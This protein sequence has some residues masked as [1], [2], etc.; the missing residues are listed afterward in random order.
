MEK[1]DQKYGG[2]KR[3]LQHYLEAI[4]RASPVEET[5]L[6]KL[7]I[8]TDRLTDVVV[9]LE[10]SDQHQELAG[11]SARYQS[12]FLSR[13]KSGCTGSPVRMDYPYFLNGCLSYGRRRS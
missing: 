10:D 13:T 9:K 4:L 12:L 7:E 3:L 6:K 11:L 2:E 8:F 1:L 5:N